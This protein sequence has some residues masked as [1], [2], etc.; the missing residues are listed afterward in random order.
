MNI[1]EI[2]IEGERSPKCIRPT[3]RLKNN[4]TVM[5]AFDTVDSMNNIIAT[6]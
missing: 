3:V 4:N 1:I 5:L 2:R 6:S